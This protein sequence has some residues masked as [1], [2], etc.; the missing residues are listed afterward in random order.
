MRKISI[1]LA[2]SMLAFSVSA[3]AKPKAVLGCSVNPIVE[4]KTTM[5]EIDVQLDAVKAPITVAN[6]TGYVKSKFYDG[7]IFHRVI[8]GFMIQGGGFDEK[9]VEAVTKAP[10][11]NEA[12]NGLA[13]DKYTIAMART[14]DPDSATAQFFINVNDNV[15]LNYSAANAGYAVF[16]KVIKGQDVADKIAMV[17]TKTVGQYENVPEKA[18]I[19]QSAKMRACK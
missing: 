9:M 8:P 7:K 12:K 15:P 4:I 19:I 18:I 14:N 13:N 1:F 5:G 2:G 16:G 11:K 17:T 3:Q 10:I 6:F